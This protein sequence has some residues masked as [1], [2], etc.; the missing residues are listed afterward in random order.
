MPIP[1]CGYILISYFFSL[2]I[3][4]KT[5]RYRVKSKGREVYDRSSTKVMGSISFL[6]G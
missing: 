2:H 6:V 3:D 1:K 5:M 4:N